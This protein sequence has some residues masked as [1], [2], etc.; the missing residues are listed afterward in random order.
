MRKSTYKQR[1]AWKCV[2]VHD[3]TIEEAAR[4]CGV[5]AR[6]IYE[7]L[8]RLRYNEPDLF[9]HRGQRPTQQSIEYMDSLNP[10][11]VREKI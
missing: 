3:M 8:E 4:R 2:F 11:G 9:P 7:R 1:Q 6:S 5:S 10:D